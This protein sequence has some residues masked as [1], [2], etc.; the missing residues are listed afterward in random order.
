MQGL[1][2]N[3]LL[4]ISDYCPVENIDLCYLTDHIA[5]VVDQR[6]TNESQLWI[7]GCSVSHGQGVDPDQRYGQLLANELELECSFLTKPGSSIQW[8]ADQLLR[9]DI[10]P[11]DIVF[12]GVTDAIRLTYVYKN[13]YLPGLTSRTYTDYPEV[14]KIVPFMELFSENTLYN[15][16]CS[17]EKVIN[18]CKKIDIKL[19]MLGILPTMP[20]FYRYIKLIPGYI[21]FPHLLKWENNCSMPV[22]LDVGTDGEHPGPIQHQHYKTFIL[23]HFDIFNQ[24]K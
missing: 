23:N 12:W 16:I 18:F 14:E 7:A 6:K 24:Q 11:G 8:A 10:R 20:N 4:A 17:V 22:Y 19:G 2:E 21:E 5:K 15:N 3:V 9:S 1:T 13:K